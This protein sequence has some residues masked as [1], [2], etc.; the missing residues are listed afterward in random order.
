MMMYCWYLVKNRL[1]LAK[2]ASKFSK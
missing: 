1:I 2:F